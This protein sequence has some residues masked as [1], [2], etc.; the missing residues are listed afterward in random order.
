MVKK[1]VRANRFGRTGSLTPCTSLRIETHNAI[2]QLEEW[3]NKTV[4]YGCGRNGS[5]LTV[6]DPVVV[7]THMRTTNKQVSKTSTEACERDILAR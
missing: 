1:T 6:V 3:F 5:R 2:T 4:S 7:P